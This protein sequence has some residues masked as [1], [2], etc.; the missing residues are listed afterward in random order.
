MASPPSFSPALF[1]HVFC[2]TF[3]GGPWPT[4]TWWLRETL[5]ISVWYDW[6]IYPSRRHPCQR[7]PAFLSPGASLSFLLVAA[8]SC[9]YDSSRSAGH[10]TPG[11]VCDTSISSCRTQ[12]ICSSYISL[13][14]LRTP[15]CTCRTNPRGSLLARRSDRRCSHRIGTRSPAGSWRRCRSGCVVFSGS[16]PCSSS[17]WL[18]VWRLEW[19]YCARGPSTIVRPFL[20]HSW[21]T[22]GL[23]CS[24]GRPQQSTTPPWR[25]ARTYSKVSHRSRG[26]NLLPA[27]WWSSLQHRYR[28]WF[29]LRWV[30][31]PSGTRQLWSLCA[32]TESSEW[33]LPRYFP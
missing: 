8:S 11:R 30:Q 7:A 29:Q 2:L 13:S 32:Q 26:V 15:P 14:F 31:E 24:N 1:P 12:T 20:S 23:F 9:T 28:S 3:A 27:L 6:A 25:C 21:A 18:A 17:I 4:R 10:C 16:G 5:P 22:L 19:P 33:R